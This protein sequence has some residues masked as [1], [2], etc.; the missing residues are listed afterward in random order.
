MSSSSELEELV[1]IL[2]SLAEKYP[3]GA[4]QERVDLYLQDLRLKADLPKKQA[5]LEAYADLINEYNDL[6]QSPPEIEKQDLEIQV[7]DAERKRDAVITGPTLS[8]EK[9]DS[10]CQHFLKF[11]GDAKPEGDA[12]Y[13]GRIATTLLKIDKADAFLNQV[14]TYK[15]KVDEGRVARDEV[16]ELKKK[17]ASLKAKA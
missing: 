1:T 9:R 6:Q 13:K 16:R 10:Y 2:K 5:E 4:D 14:D 17:L 3:G 7:K 15:Q 12:D 8:D 11:L